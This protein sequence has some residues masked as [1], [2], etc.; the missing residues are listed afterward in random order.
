MRPEDIQ[1]LG[2]GA[3]KQILEQLGKQ[4]AAKAAKRKYN[5]V[6]TVRQT[7][8][9]SIRFDSAA[10]A[11]RYDE[12]M[13]LRDAGEIEML[14]LQPEF[15]LMDAWTSPNGDRIRAIRYRADFAYWKDGKLVVEDVKSKAT[16]TKEYQIKK[17]VMANQ[18][19]IEIQEIE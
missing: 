8:T 18:L 6:P 7:P 15:T 17:K 14:R 13:L 4:E 2:P 5:N 3:R 11:R 1:R 10:E 19:G 9:G 12:L 16:K